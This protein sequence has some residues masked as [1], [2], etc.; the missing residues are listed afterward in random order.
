MAAVAVLV[1]GCGQGTGAA[2][3]PASPASV[4]ASPSSRPAA[5]PS[6]ALS[7][8]PVVVPVPS[9]RAHEHQTGA[10]PPAQSHV[11]RAEMTDLWAAVASGRPQLGM[12]AFFPVVA[13]D[14]VKAIGDPAA[15]WQNRLVAEYRL[16]IRAAHRLLDGH[17][18]AA[19]LIGVIV[20][21]SESGWISP[22]VCDNGIGYWHVAGARLVYRVHG[23]TRSFG[24][25]TLISW[26]GRWYVV[27]LGGELRTGSGG[28]VDQPSLGTGTPGPA[29]GC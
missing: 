6:P 16:D 10:R 28:M 9:V 27:H 23:Q 4:A 2:G 8:W 1:A 18:R 11:F 22:G 25:A 20:P 7:A 14:Q 13:Y 29:G 15:D 17:G 19:K 21:E 26:R 3:R 24:I 5:S 12:A